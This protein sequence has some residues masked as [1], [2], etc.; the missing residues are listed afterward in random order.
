MVVNPMCVLQGR[1]LQVLIVVSTFLV[2]TD[3]RPVTIII[4]ADIIGRTVD[5]QFAIIIIV[6]FNQT[7]E[8]P[9]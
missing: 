6:P 3:H 1:V 9:D 8:R 5:Q 2:V 4:V 7:T